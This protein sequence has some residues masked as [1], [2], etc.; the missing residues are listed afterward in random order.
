MKFSE[1]SYYFY[2]NFL[3]FIYTDCDSRIVDFALFVEKFA[4]EIFG[5]VTVKKEDLFYLSTRIEKMDLRWM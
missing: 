5:E 2:Y 3:D 4:V 1:L